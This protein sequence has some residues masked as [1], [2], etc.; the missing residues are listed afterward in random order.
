MFVKEILGDP[1][2]LEPRW[3]RVPLADAITCV[4]LVVEELQGPL[5]LAP[6][7][8]LQNCL[9]YAGRLR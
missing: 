9:D 1:L 3:L 5:A 8:E 6:F 4:R 2:K 7:L